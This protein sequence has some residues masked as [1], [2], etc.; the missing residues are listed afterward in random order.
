M[1]KTQA[2][3]GEINPNRANDPSPEEE[4]ATLAEREHSLRAENAERA[5]HKELHLLLNSKEN[6]DLLR[7]S[8]QELLHKQLKDTLAGN[9]RATPTV[10]NGLA[11]E[12]EQAFHDAHGE[13]QQYQSKLQS[14]QRALGKPYGAYLELKLADML[15]EGKI[16]AREI[17]A[18]DLE[19]ILALEPDPRQITRS[20][21]F[22]TIRTGFPDG[23]ARAKMATTLERCI[24]DAVIGQCQS[25]D[26]SVIRQWGDA[27]FTSMYSERAG[28]VNMHLDP[29][30]SVVQQYG[31]KILCDLVSGSCSP[32]VLSSMSVAELCPAAFKK[33]YDEIELRSRQRVKEKT[34]TLYQCPKCK[35]R[36]CTYRE[37]QTRSLDESATIYCTCN[38][39]DSRFQ[40]NS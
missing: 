14:V 7:G 37:V 38:V 3:S 1:E 6:K 12:L 18:K 15:V 34:S 24:Y 11:C 29:S 36:D 26:V 19:P 5:L 4:A 32:Q 17:A 22:R 10:I 13:Q 33:E 40:G 16:T 30:S 39:C 31:G 28:V 23:Q 35:E 25:S 2:P 27:E 8:F 9:P 21:L 20:L